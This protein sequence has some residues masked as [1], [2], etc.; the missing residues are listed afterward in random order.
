MTKL[1]TK[2]KEAEASAA[3][4]GKELEKLN[5]EYSQVTEK[6][7]TPSRDFDELANFK[8]RQQQ[9]P[10]LVF[11]ATV[12]A[13]KASI[14]VMEIKRDIAVEARQEAVRKKEERMRP[15]EAEIADA[16]R[17]VLDLKMDRGSLFDA[18]NSADREA[19]TYTAR[20]HHAET[21][22]REYIQKASFNPESFKT[23]KSNIVRMWPTEIVNVDTQ[24]A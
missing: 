20:I 3:A 8:R 13:R 12:K 11:D 6:L 17:R 4:A 7:N 21:D 24:A 10:E 14:A 18:V 9:L 1:E 19:A 22:L 5:A 16:E 23:E 15:L 2:L